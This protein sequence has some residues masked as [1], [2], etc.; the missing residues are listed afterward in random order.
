[1]KTVRSLRRS[2]AGTV[3]RLTRSDGMEPLPACRASSTTASRVALS[4]A[5]GNR[6]RAAC[7]SAAREPSS[8][9]AAATTRPRSTRGS[10]SR[11]ARPANARSR[12]R[13]AAAPRDTPASGPLPKVPMDSDSARSSAA[14]NDRRLPAAGVSLQ[15]HGA[16]SQ[17]RFQCARARMGLLRQ[18]EGRGRSCERE[19]GEGRV[20]RLP[21]RRIVHTHRHVLPC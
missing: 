4:T 16:S 12:T 1:M 19:L 8:A 2:S 13:A 5:G 10:T 21:P 6:A 17:P 7:S 9:R 11:S 3:P 18:R 14:P 15:A 20:L